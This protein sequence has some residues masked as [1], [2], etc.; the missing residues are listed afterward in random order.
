MSSAPSNASIEQR[1][2]TSHAPARPPHR[3]QAL[4]DALVPDAHLNA[5]V[6]GIRGSGWAGCASGPRADVDQSRPLVAPHGRARGGAQ[7]LLR[8]RCHWPSVPGLPP[9]HGR[10]SCTPAARRRSAD[11]LGPPVGRR[12]PAVSRAAASS[13]RCA[14]SLGCEQT[15][16]DAGFE[17]ARAPLFEG[18]AAR[19]DSPGLP[20]ARR[21]EAGPAGERVEDRAARGRRAVCGACFQA[22]PSEERLLVQERVRGPLVSVELVLDRE[23]RLVARFQQVTRRTWPSAAGSI[24]LA[25]SV[26]P[27]EGLVS[28]TAA[29]LAELGYWGLAQVDFV[30]TASG[31]TLLD[32]NPRFFRCMPLAVAC[33]T[34]LPRCGTRSRSGDRSEALAPTGPGMT[35]RW[36]EA[37]LIAAARGAPA[38][39]FE[40]APQ[41]RH[42]GGVGRGRPA[43]RACS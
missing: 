30:E 17:D 21:R 36:L 14:T 9:T 22:S 33:G 26:E 8:A 35:Y 29:M 31:Y 24:A 5:A 19:G 27:N 2:M 7:C 43:A 1:L 32:V 39:L 18:S 15:A 3:G 13:S 20:V 37:D 6:A 25:T 10:S 28:R 40:R 11:A 41:P 38:R 4:I 16:A 23:G 12:G 34:N 42:R